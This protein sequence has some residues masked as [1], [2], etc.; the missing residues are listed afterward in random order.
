[1]RHVCVAE[2]LLVVCGSPDAGTF[3]RWGFGWLLFVCWVGLI[4][5]L[6]AKNMYQKGVPHP[7]TCHYLNP[8]DSWLE[9]KVRLERKGAI[10]EKR[11]SIVGK[12][13]FLKKTGRQEVRD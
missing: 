5:F 1:M 4:F 12:E 3:T 7:H 9:Q 11:G 13:M 2:G 10:L 6:Y 8:K